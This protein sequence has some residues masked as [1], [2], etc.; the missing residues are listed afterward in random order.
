MTGKRYKVNKE[1]M[2]LRENIGKLILYRP[3]DEKP[4]KIAI[5]TGVHPKTNSLICLT[6]K[7]KQLKIPSHQAA[8]IIG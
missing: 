8:E 5:C 6:P 2:T 4:Y 3:E 7:G 1:A